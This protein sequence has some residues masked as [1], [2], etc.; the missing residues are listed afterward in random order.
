MFDFS[1]YMHVCLIFL[2]DLEH[3]GV[4][5]VGGALGAKKELSADVEDINAGKCNLLMN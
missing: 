3:S 2:Q 4:H 5:T 1:D